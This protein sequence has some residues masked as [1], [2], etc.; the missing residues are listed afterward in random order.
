[1]FARLAFAVAIRSEP[2]IL[3]LDEVFAVGD[4]AFKKKSAETMQQLL[5][6]AGTI[7]M[8]SHGLGRLRRF[9]HRLAWMD[10]GRLMEIGDPDEITGRY[11]AFL[12]ISEEEAEGD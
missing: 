8:V 1:M 6:N 10:Q 12:G 5:E 4:Q 3:L 7:V 11:L 2:Q 9:C